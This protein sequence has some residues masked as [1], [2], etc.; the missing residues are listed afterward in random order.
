MGCNGAEDTPA[1]ASRQGGGLSGLY[2]KGR[3]NVHPA[4]EIEDDNLCF[5]SGLPAGRPATTI[6]MLTA[7]AETMVTTTPILARSLKLKNP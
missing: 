6:P 5:Y 7:M 3:V 2:G 4:L 1:S